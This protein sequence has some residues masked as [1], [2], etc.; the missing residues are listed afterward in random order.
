MKKYMEKTR[1]LSPSLYQYQKTEEETSEREKKKE[2]KTATISGLKRIQATNVGAERN[3]NLP[4]VSCGAVQSDGAAQPHPGP[5]GQPSIIEQPNPRS[6]EI[7]LP[8]ARHPPSPPRVPTIPSIT[9]FQQVQ[10]DL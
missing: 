3:N 9:I 6:A 10:Q 2:R 5:V 4:F 1:S 8:V 7:N